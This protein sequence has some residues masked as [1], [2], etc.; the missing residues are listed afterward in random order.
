M[1][2]PFQDGI[3]FVRCFQAK[4]FNLVVS[5][6]HPSLGKMKVQL[7]PLSIYPL[8]AVP[9]LGGGG[10]TSTGSGTSPVPPSS[11]AS[12]G[13]ILHEQ[14]ACASCH[15]T[16][17]GASKAAVSGAINQIGQMKNYNNGQLLKLSSS[18][19]DKITAYLASGK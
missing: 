11:T 8:T 14:N 7:G 4:E 10:G 6:K 19:L 5:F 18:D 3:F 2:D 13:Q 1:I 12:E 15:T 16:K 9:I 17:W